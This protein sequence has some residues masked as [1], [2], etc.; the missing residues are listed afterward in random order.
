MKTT[1]FLLLLGCTMMIFAQDADLQS[2]SGPL[3]PAG[4]DATGHESGSKAL[5]T[6]IPG[7]PAY[8]WYRGC[9]PTSLGMIFGYYDTHGFPGLIPGDASTQTAAVNTAIA[10]TGHYSD[11]SLPLDYYPNL[12]SDLSEPPAGDEHSDD[13][14]AD[15]MLTSRSS[16]SNYWGW[17]WSSGICPA[18]NA[19]LNM[20]GQYTGS[21]NSLAAS[22]FSF[23]DL[24]AEINAN[25]PLMFLVDT[26]G[27]NSTD[28]FITVAGWQTDAG[29]D[30]YGCYHTWDANIH[31]YEYR[32]M[33]NGIP[34]GVYRVYPFTVSTIVSE[35][36][37]H[38]I[39]VNFSVAPNPAQDMIILRS[40][41]PLDDSLQI[42]LTDIRGSLVFEVKP[43]FNTQRSPYEWQVRLPASLPGGVYLLHLS[44][45]EQR[46]ILK[47]CTAP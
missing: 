17:S 10:S 6:V 39:P 13:C 18:F 36:P 20:T 31:W 35:L 41:R 4:V 32:G 3:P 29:V 2:S 1:L 45:G 8:Q 46:S 19:Y 15:F 34:W 44:R 47:L 12:L 40:D 21:C 30:Y 22:A 14:I 26:D 42:M 23:A 28:H 25:R 9:G 11:Y 5:I 33:Q 7:V 16:V 24:Q 43:D 38:E 37:E 27:D